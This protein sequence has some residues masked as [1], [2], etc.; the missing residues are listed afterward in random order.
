MLL[1]ATNRRLRKEGTGVRVASRK[2]GGGTN[3][4]EICEG[5]EVKKTKKVSK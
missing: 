5:I 4:N 2:E 3:G 1:G